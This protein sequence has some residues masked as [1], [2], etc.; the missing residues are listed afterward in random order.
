[1]DPPKQVNRRIGRD[2]G[3]YV[4]YNRIEGMKFIESLRGKYPKSDYWVIGCDPN[5]DFYPDDFFD[6]KLSITLNFA[7]IAFPNSTYFC[8][9]HTV[10]ANGIVNKLGPDYLS[11]C[12]FVALCQDYRD[13][14]S[15]IWW[16]NYGL[17]PIY[18]KVINKHYSKID[19]EDREK[20]IEQISNQ[21]QFELVG[22][23]GVV[24]HAMQIAF[25]FGA[26]KIILVGCSNRGGKVFYH[27]QKR[28]LSEF[29]KDKEIDPDRLES[30][31]T[32]RIYNVGNKERE[33]VMFI[34][35]FKKHGIEIVKHR[36]DEEK[37]EFIFEK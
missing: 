3:P 17:D 2:Y 25:L 23:F 24:N 33:M 28:G 11:K 1:H 15:N 12:I 19:N 35:L 10:V 13:P 14:I 36:F 26:K 31:R 22:G 7:C 21:G 16:E 32:G 27:A 6:D 29:Y 8:T 34:G 18:A 30:Y 5:I 4:D 9:S 20:M 37:E